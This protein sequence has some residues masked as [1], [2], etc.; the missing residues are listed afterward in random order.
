[1]IEKYN[2]RTVEYS[3]DSPIITIY[4]ANILIYRRIRTRFKHGRQQSIIV[5]SIG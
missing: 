3:V 1:M 5:Q 2:I 4:L